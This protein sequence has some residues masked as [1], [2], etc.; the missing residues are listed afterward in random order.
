MSFEECLQ[1]LETECDMTFDL[2]M[3]SEAGKRDI[4]EMIYVFG[5]AF[6]SL[7]KQRRREPVT[8]SKNIKMAIRMM[9]NS[10]KSGAIVNE[11]KAEKVKEI[12]T[13]CFNPVDMS[14]EMDK[15]KSS[16]TNGK[17]LNLLRGCTHPKKGECTF[18]PGAKQ[19]ERANID[20]ALAAQEVIGGEVLSDGSASR[21][22]EILCLDFMLEKLGLVKYGDTNTVI[23]TT[24][25][26]VRRRAVTE[27]RRVT[28]CLWPGRCS[29]TC[30]AR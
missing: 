27:A 18:F 6:R 29:S 15:S 13:T 30:S 17:S 26:G 22:D 11:I 16:C 5:K 14:V 1:F 2:D 25:I 21:L 9:C 4:I 19:I 12:K 10:Y 23:P 8:F 3:L 20:I 24:S 7:H 28:T